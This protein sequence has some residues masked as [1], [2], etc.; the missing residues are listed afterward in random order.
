MKPA[1]QERKEDN[2]RIAMSGTQEA[3]EEFYLYLLLYYI[4]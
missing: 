4:C 1:A 3:V 2:A